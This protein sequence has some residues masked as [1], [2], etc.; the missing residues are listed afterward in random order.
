MSEIKKWSRFN[1]AASTNN[2]IAE[3]FVR[4]LVLV[5]ASPCFLVAALSAQIPTA[6][7]VL[8]WRYDL[9]HS[10][11]N[12]SETAL[13]PTN[14]NP[15]TFG[16][17]FS[18][19]VDSTTYAQPLYVPGLKMSDGETHNVL[20]VATSNDSVYA[21]D[22]DSNGGTNAQPI[23]KISL[24]T[25]DHGAGA[26]AAAV[27]WQDTGSP[28]VAPTVGITGTPTIDP[29]TNTMYLVANTK[30]NGTYFS[31]LHAI[32]IVTGAERPN[33]PANITATVAGT[34]NGSSGGQLA[35]SPLW[36]NQRTALD[37]YNGY[38]YFGY[39]AHGDNGPWHG[40]L[41][42]YNAS[43]LA[44]SA[45]LCLSPN[46]SGAG[47]WA[48]GAGLPI[49]N[50][51]AGGRM[52]VVT[53]NGTHSTYPPF[54]L[55]TEFGESV[56]NLSLANGSLTPTDA[57][58]PFNYQI[59]NDHDWDLGS[60]GI[61]MI[62]DQQGTHP[63]VLVV[64]G[65][66]GRI[67]V[68]NRDNLGGYA[69]GASSNTNAL[70]DISTA[71]PQAKGFWSTP[72]YW[73]GNVYLW[74]ENNVPML[75]KMNTGVMET[76]PDS[77]SD[78]TSAFPD[79]SFSI[80]S[81]GTQNGVA[82][83]VRSD[84]FNT[85]GAAVLYAWDANDL[86]KTIYESDSNA[87]RDAAG[88]ANKFSIP[89]VTNGKVYVAENGEVDVYGLLNG[90]LSAAAPVIAPNGG[91][92]SSAQSVT[93]STT[94][95]SAAIYYTLDGS[96]P[97]TAS[98]LYD[99]PISVSTNTTIEA[100][101][102][103]PG[104]LQ[105]PVSSATFTFTT[106]TPTVTFTPAPGTYLAAQSV[107]LLDTDA[108]AKIYYTTDGSAPTASSIVYTGAIQ[109]AASE[110]IK[111]IAIDPTLQSSN[112][113]TATYVIQNGGT[114]IDFGMGFSSTAGLTLNGSAVATNDTRLQL[115]NG[116]LNQAGSVFWNAPIG[117]NAFTTNFEFQL[118]SAQA[119]GFTFCIQNVAPTALGGSSAGL[120][121]QDILK[122]VAVKFN[123]YNYQNEGSDSTGVY[124]NGEPPLLPT[125]DISP[126]GIQLN[127]GDSI[128]AQINYD[129]QNLTLTLLDLVNSKTFT[130]SQPIN[131][132]QIV[133]GNAAYV[134]F[135]GGTGG[136]SASQK[137]LTWTYN[138]QAT[139]APNIS[140]NGGTF[141]SP[142]SVTLSTTTPSAAIYY[143]LDG[144]A[145]TSASTLYKGPIA[146]ST[147]T[148][149]R[150]LASAAGFLPSAVSTAT[151]TFT[152]QA[153]P[154][155]FSPTP[156]TYPAAQSVTLSDTDANAKI[157]YTTD[158]ST[159]SASSTLYTTAISVATS[160][161][162]K[163]I[164]IDAALQNSNIASAAYVIQPL[165][166]ITPTV[167]FAPAAGTYGSAQSVTLADTDANAKIYYT[168]DGSAP[169]ASSTLYT[170]AISVATSETI[171]AIAIDAALQNSNI[172]SAAYVIQPVIAITP[173]VTFAPAPG[174][175]GSA[176]SV[177]LADTDANAKIYYTID[178]STP[179]ASSTL[180]TSAISVATSETINA[181]AI[182]SAMQN[183]S[184][185]MAAYIIQVA[186]GDPSFAMSGSPVSAI[187]AGSSS[188]STITITP[189]GGFTGTI[190]FGC[191]VAGGPSGATNIPTCS[192]DR[193]AS[194]SGSQ[195][196][197][198]TLTIK[199]A[200][201]SSTVASN[202]FRH[203]VALGGASL[204]AFLFLLPI[205]RRR[206]QSLIGMVLLVFLLSTA[207]GCGG[208]TPAQRG[209][210]G[211]TP[212]NYVATVTGTSSTINAS[213]TVAF[214]VQ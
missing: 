187:K 12:T 206:W 209:T 169:S 193:S 144:S 131:I 167:T 75:F 205:R 20:F 59:L 33:S 121:Y 6:V 157:Y 25:A 178:G 9:T 198:A 45:V 176:Q 172:A 50:D 128:Q 47:L 143:T 48:S 66:E 103:A 142:Q 88:A 207:C 208:V 90:Q 141:S 183:S 82:W 31:R 78:I 124:T 159:P 55:N 123:F 114:T 65:K 71:I 83:A 16:K 160:E 57:F 108:S 40:W 115:T 211:T 102:S 13:T 122:S 26:G 10:G 15:D 68:L 97:T 153:P 112:V 8:T 168:I 42:A 51:A 155:T 87:T 130:M 3:R 171:K 203:M 94:T 56:V 7:P 135:T 77:K 179:S 105:S 5:V 120:G 54:D 170:T 107:T 139:A 64:A 11:Q 190:M 70:Q 181:I 39:G 154:V 18:L 30:E 213:T 151:F 191:T 17:L 73:N 2:A 156:G 100:I 98:T 27:P 185:V 214:T 199:T 36:E 95:T 106:Q 182:D 192:I 166:A 117:I 49:D 212:G 164:A 23:W 161:T 202:S 194:I 41:F 127:S 43:T 111:A 22:A 58:T 69:A 125:I 110:I 35:F 148:T 76:D 201:T 173:A 129:G 189:S 146:M 52:F 137:I 147:N 116:G 195:P 184:I 81:N 175:Y 162:I 158:G 72:A 91:T 80:S 85:N 93:L 89:L 150:A 46:G 4:L 145:P 14:V 19:S 53:G 1:C 188:T 109:V 126:S 174:T 152:A 79:P 134:G 177:T 28:D 84:Q 86:T 99:G 138:E 200:A 62:P 136:L 133:G 38:V 196:A 119:N 24:L 210:S 118:S 21:F 67:I 204:A 104:F 44:Q 74:A 61:L 165:I 113:A 163:A 63:H 197:S 96:T 92:F 37:L 34:G 140:P 180:Y 186:A 32:D 132:P 101:A 29:A 60:G 149:I